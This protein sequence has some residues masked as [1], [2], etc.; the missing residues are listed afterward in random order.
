M[1]A[2][3]SKTTNDAQFR[4]RV[5]RRRLAHCV[6]VDHRNPDCFHDWHLGAP[7]D[8][9]IV[10]HAGNGSCQSAL[11]AVR[12]GAEEMNREATMRRLLE[13]LA[14]CALLSMSTTEETYQT[15]CPGGQSRIIQCE[16]TNCR[17]MQ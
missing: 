4:F 11:S 1:T 3:A 12:E 9:D 8:A 13:V 16:F 15:A 6:V 14:M 17:V 7:S 10:V 2:L 5:R